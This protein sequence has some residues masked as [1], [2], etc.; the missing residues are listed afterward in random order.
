MSEDPLLPARLRVAPSPTGDPHVGTAYMSLFNLAWARKTGGQFVLRIEDTDQA[1]LRRRLRAAD[2][3]HAALAGAWAGTRAPTSAARTPP[4]GSPSGS[5]P[6]VPFVEQLIADGHAYYCW[7]SRSGWR[8]CAPSSRRPSRPSPATTG[9]ASARPARSARSCPASA[10]PPSCACSSRRRRR[11]GFD[12]P[13]SGAGVGAASPRRPG[14]PEGRRVPDLPPGRRRRRPPDGHHPRRA[15]RGVDQLDP[16]AHCCCTAGWAG[17]CPRSRTCRCCATPTSPRSPSARTRPPGW[18]GSASRAICPRRCVNFLQLLGYPPAEDEQEV[19]DFDQFVAGLR[20]GQGEHG[21][22]GLRPGQAEL[23]QRALHP[24]AKIAFLLAS[25]DEIVIADD[26]R[27][28][29]PPNARRC[30]TPPCRRWRRWSR[31]VTTRSRR[32]S[33][34]PWWRTVGSSRGWPLARCGS[35]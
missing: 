14:D 1:A 31:G 30:W 11:P 6:T 25:D 7:C 9:C 16:Q 17:T 24:P 33:G 21:R 34:E 20:L 22:A 29:L 27:A 13:R 15:R 19:A 23:A 4:T 5:T 2:L 3:R 32:R 18:C 12:R 8:S 35:P 28:T 26:A 10:R